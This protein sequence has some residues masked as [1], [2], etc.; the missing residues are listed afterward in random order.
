M[1]TISYN[2]PNADTVLG[3]IRKFI[4]GTLGM[5]REE[6]VVEKL[7][8]LPIG[9]TEELVEKCLASHVVEITL[10]LKWN[11]E[12]GLPEDNILMGKFVAVEATKTGLKLTLSIKGQS[13]HD[14]G[15]EQCEKP[16][17]IKDG[18]WDLMYFQHGISY[19][20]I[21][22]KPKPLINPNKD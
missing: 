5:L 21:Y 7:V 15:F 11:K 6:I 2:I 1:F 13:N 17:L 12:R 16:N 19:I 10:P 8:S 14:F 9:W 3:K 18:E 22:F 4:S 20:S